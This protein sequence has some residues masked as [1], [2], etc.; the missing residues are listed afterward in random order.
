MKYEK[1]HLGG[2][3]NMLYYDLVNEDIFNMNFYVRIIVSNFASWILRINY[4]LTFARRK[5]KGVENRNPGFSYKLY[6]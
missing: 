1:Y 6:R 5:E 3:D 2:Y 4:L